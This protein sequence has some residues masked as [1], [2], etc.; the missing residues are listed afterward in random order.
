[1]IVKKLLTLT[2]T[3]M[4]TTTTT[5]KDNNSTTKS[6]QKWFPLESNPALLNTYISN[7][8]FNT[9][10]YKW[11]DVFSTE[12]WAL[13]MIP[14]HAVAVLMLYP[15]SDAQLK[16]QAA[17]EKQL[18]DGDDDKDGKKETSSGA[19]GGDGDATGSGTTSSSTTTPV[20]WHMKQRIGN[21]CGT[22]GV[23]H[24]LGNISPEL[25]EAAIPPQSWLGNF[26]SSCDKQLD[27]VGKA[28]LLEGDTEIE[29]LH[30]KATESEANQTDRGNLDDHLITHFV[31]LVKVDGGLYEMDGRKSRAIRHGDTTE[32]TFLADA[33]KVVEKFM[34]RDPEELRF[35]IMALAPTQEE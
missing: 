30:D 9:S 2:L 6:N 33:C 35:T 3:T 1:M 19:E 26:Y 15:L 22:I 4:A 10:L 17:E 34:K 16:F 23:L 18:K 21:A 20:V 11:Y 25:T 24:A 12:E 31:A 29:K 8:G 5:K 7:L 32:E 13:S 14:Q 27:S 28:E